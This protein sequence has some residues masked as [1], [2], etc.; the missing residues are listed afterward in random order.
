MV[1]GEAAGE[2][3]YAKSYWEGSVGFKSREDVLLLFCG[4][5]G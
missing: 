4:R 1:E 3:V 5:G 2:T